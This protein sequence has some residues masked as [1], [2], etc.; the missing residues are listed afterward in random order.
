[1]KRILTALLLIVSVVAFA[2]KKPYTEIKDSLTAFPVSVHIGGLIYD[3]TSK[4]MWAAKQVVNI[5]DSLDEVAKYQIAGTGLDTNYWRKTG[6]GA[7]DTTIH[8]IGTKDSK[9]VVF[10]TNNTRRGGINATNGYWNIT[11]RLGIN[12]LAPT[13][14]LH[15]ETG[16]GT[17]NFKIGGDASYLYATTD[18]DFQFWAQGSVKLYITSTENTSTVQLRPLANGTLALGTTSY[19]WSAAYAN[20]FQSEGS[21]LR[22]WRSA[23]HATANTAGTGLIIQGSGATSGSNNKGASPTI[24]RAGEKTGIWSSSSV[25]VQTYGSNAASTSDNTVYDRAVF[26]STESLI[27]NTLDTLFRVTL[28]DDSTFTGTLNYSIVVSDNDS[29]QVEKGYCELIY[30]RRGSTE[31][32][33]AT[34]VMTQ[35][36]QLGTLSTTFSYIWNQAN[37][38]V[39]VCVNAN[40]TTHQAIT[41]RGNIMLR[42]DLIGMG[43]RFTTFTEF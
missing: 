26:M 11:S 8:F 4:K 13:S 36:L 33:N 38:Y 2:Q 41:T 10:K 15:I 39:Y 43:G 28:G 21:T 23:R 14:P 32:T 3:T 24:I 1:M 35:V 9:G 16:T 19:Y 37:K 25:H 5:G 42:G 6:N 7:T 40:S 30:I 18:K 27:D 34:Q 17:A 22:T 29:A 12:T 20:A 31:L